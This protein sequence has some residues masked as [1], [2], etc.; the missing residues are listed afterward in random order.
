MAQSRKYRSLIR[1]CILLCL[2]YF[3]MEDLYFAP[4]LGPDTTWYGMVQFLARIF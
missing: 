2:L 1:S 4:S 3:T